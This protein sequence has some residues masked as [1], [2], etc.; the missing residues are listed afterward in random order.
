MA[1]TAVPAP[2]A[3][4][5]YH[6][7]LRDYHGPCRFEQLCGACPRC[8]GHD[9]RLR[10]THIESGEPLS[11]VRLQSV[12]ATVPAPGDTDEKP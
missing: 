4:V 12:S 6:G 7:S 2:G 1:L 10:L 8:W 9:Q 11:C 3:T 5:E